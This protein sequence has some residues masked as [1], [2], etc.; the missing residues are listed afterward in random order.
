MNYFD[1][2]NEALKPYREYKSYVCLL[3]TSFCSEIY[4]DCELLDYD[5]HSSEMSMSEDE[6]GIDNVVD[7]IKK[8]ISKKYYAIVETNQYHI[9]GTSYYRKIQYMHRQLF[10]GYSD[11]YKCFYT[12]GYNKQR[13]YR[14]LAIPYEEIPKAT[15]EYDIK[16]AAPIHL[17]LIHI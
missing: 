5:I 8:L 6:I 16:L 13:K 1:V 11:I 14:S 12:L 17:S 15:I 7:Y 4:T 9:P 10:Y 2:N 3:Y